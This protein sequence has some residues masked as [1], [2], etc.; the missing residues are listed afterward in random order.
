MT[1]SLQLQLL[2]WLAAL[3]AIGAVAKPNLDT[4]LF[5]VAFGLGTCLL[6]ARE[7]WRED[8]LR[9]R[10]RIVGE[11]F[12]AMVAWG[13]ALGR[14]AMP[15]LS[16]VP[17]RLDAPTLV[18]AAI[19]PSVILLLRAIFAVRTWRAMKAFERARERELDS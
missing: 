5:A 1:R 7:Y 16:R 2:A 18:L 9:P 6:R 14:H 15:D 12:G 19:I 4:L 3:A 10:D 11:T 17:A 8:R 13:A